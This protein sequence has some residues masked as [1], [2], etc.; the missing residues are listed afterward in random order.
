LGDV[1]GTEHANVDTP[2][3]PAILRLSRARIY[4]HLVGD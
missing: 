1:A 2:R 4:L 3:K